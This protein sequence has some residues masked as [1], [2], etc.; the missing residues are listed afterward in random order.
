MECVVDNSTKVP[1]DL[2][3]PLSDLIPYGLNYTL[4]FHSERES[5]CCNVVFI[6][7]VVRVTPPNLCQ[8]KDVTCLLTE[9]M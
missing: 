1:L 8:P 7:G 5:S 3:T 4:T 9:V 6:T 2:N